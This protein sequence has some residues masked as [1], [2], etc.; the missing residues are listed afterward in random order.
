MQERIK[1]LNEC[2]NDTSKGTDEY[3]DI[4]NEMKEFELI[5]LMSKPIIRFPY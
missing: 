1:Y 2:L 4:Y 3:N 5:D